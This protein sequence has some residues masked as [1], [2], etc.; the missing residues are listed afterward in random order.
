MW[1]RFIGLVNR[2]SSLGKQIRIIWGSLL[3][4]SQRGCAPELGSYST[5]HD[6]EPKFTYAQ[7]A[8][9]TWDIAR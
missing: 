2:D 1:N 9:Q 8:I 4:T 7:M 3:N 5:L 6:G